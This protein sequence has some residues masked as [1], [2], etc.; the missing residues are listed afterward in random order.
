[1]AARLAALLLLAGALAGPARADDDGL[2]ETPPV[3]RHLMNLRLGD[4]LNHVKSIYPPLGDW[5][6]HVEPR[7]RVTR[8]RVEREA[9]KAFPKGV[10]TIWLGFKRGSLVDIQVIYDDETTRERP[11]SQLA[12]DVSLEYGEPRRTEN[13]FWWADGRTVLRV[14]PAEVPVL[15][16]GKTQA[17]WR[18]SIQ[19]VEQGLFKRVD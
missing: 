9:V 10:Q 5:P 19:V 11:Y 3:Q 2:D 18:T 7:G 12:V 15:V 1:M 4:G 6:S 16:E 17:V 13:R 8:Y 14:F